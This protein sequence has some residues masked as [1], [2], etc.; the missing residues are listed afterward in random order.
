MGVEHTAQTLP[1]GCRVLQRTTGGETATSFSNS[2]ILRYWHRFSGI[3]CYTVS[4][5]FEPTLQTVCLKGLHR[6]EARLTS[7]KVM[8]YWWHRCFG[9]TYYRV[10]VGVEHKVQTPCLRTAGY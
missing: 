7:V 3:T 10:R 5:S 4:V 1:Q 9:S 6:Q 8:L 2:D